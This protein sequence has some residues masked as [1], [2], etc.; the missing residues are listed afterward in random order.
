MFTWLTDPLAHGFFARGTLELLLLAPLCGGLGIWLIAFRQGYATESLAHGSFPGVVL[1][2]L[3][4]VPL[5]FGAVAGISV[6]ALTT[7]LLSRGRKVKRD[8]AVAATTTTL[9]SF[10]VLIA[11]APEASPRLDGF[12]FG[13]PLGVSQDDLTLAAALLIVGCVA[14]WRSHRRLSVIAFDIQSARAL[15]A[16]PLIAEMTIL[17]VLSLALIGAIPAL[18]NLL[19]I[20]LLI[21][22]AATAANL[23]TSL[24][25]R[26]ACATAIA[27]LGSILGLYV[28]Y[29]LEIATGAS[30]ALALIAL[31]ALS[32]VIATARN[33]STRRANL[34]PLPDT[35]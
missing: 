16:S 9:L 33:L 10:G 19:T 1:A 23:T 15:G 31:Y 13:D 12:L 32:L 30:V 11:L 26:A 25:R 7:A 2:S 24:L 22:P 28:S 35:A 3:A 6:A 14:L 21:A 5:G 4:G 34:A 27:A 18:G 20:A 8:I 17:F 29:Y